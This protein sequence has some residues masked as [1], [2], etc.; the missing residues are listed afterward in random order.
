MLDDPE[1]GANFTL[2]KGE[3]VYAENVEASYEC[4]EFGSFRLMVSGRLLLKNGVAVDLGGRA[5]DLLT[6]LTRRAFEVVSSREL[7]KLVWPDVVVEEANLRGCV[8]ALRKVLGHRSEGPRYIVT[9]V[10]RGYAFV[11]PVKHIGA[12]DHIRKVAVADGRPSYREASLAQ[13][14]CA[15][16]DTSGKPEPLSH[17]QDSQSMSNN[18]SDTQGGSVTRTLTVVSYQW[19]GAA[20]ASRQRES[21]RVTNA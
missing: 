8:A 13:N 21:R 6:A 9:I 2:P 16:I 7:M 12:T 5:F 1:T 11:A 18:G 19:Q 3:C 17:Q 20:F 15:F 14:V 10:G 4:L